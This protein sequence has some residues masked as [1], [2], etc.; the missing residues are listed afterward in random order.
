ML[1]PMPRFEGAVE[2]NRANQNQGD[3]SATSCNCWRQSPTRWKPRRPSLIAMAAFI[4]HSPIVARASFF[5][6]RRLA[7]QTTN[8][9]S[10][11][12]M[13]ATWMPGSTPPSYLDGSMPWCG[14]WSSFDCVYLS[15]CAARTN[16]SSAWRDPYVSPSKS[17]NDIA[18][19][20]LRHLFSSCVRP[21]LSALAWIITAA[22]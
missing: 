1:K 13:R 4:S 19:C 12:S 5:A 8:G 18:P 21:L 20:V 22:L 7:T 15:L 16:C 14:S 9:T 6:G 2:S 11:V 3:R 17:W 10:K